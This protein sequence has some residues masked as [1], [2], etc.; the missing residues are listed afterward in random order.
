M[1]SL[2]P[3]RAISRNM[4]GL[5]RA[6]LSVVSQ[7]PYA[8][9]KWSVNFQIY[10]MYPVSTAADEGSYSYGCP[11]DRW[12]NRFLPRDKF[13]GRVSRC[14]RCI[15]SKSVHL[16]WYSP[17]SGYYEVVKST[18]QALNRGLEKL[19]WLNAYI[20]SSSMS[21]ASDGFLID[22]LCQPAQMKNVHGEVEN[23]MPDRSNT[24]A[25]IVWISNMDSEASYSAPLDRYQRQR[26]TSDTYT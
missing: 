12:V 11:D 9:P 19:R 2:A 24:E 14:K 22:L 21:F 20:A 18:E 10:N 5:D 26:R 23:R 25:V 15:G 13:R 7:I 4:E 6:I 17:F 1:A 8:Q 16:Y 3:T